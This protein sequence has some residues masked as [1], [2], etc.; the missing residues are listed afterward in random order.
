MKNKSQKNR[1]LWIIFC[2]LIKKI[3]NQFQNKQFWEYA[4]VKHIDNYL[5]ATPRTGIFIKSIL[6]K[7]K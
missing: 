6:E 2:F 5:K 7:N 1:I 4:W 3:M